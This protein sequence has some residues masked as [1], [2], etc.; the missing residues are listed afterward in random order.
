M[1]SVTITPTSLFFNDLPDEL[2]NALTTEFALNLVAYKK[3][4]K[5]DGTPEQLFKALLKLSYKYD[6]DLI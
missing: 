2:Y 3:G 6:I 5:L 1:L 4:H